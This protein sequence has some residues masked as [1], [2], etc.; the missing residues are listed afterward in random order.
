V[1]RIDPIIYINNARFVIYDPAED[2]VVINALEMINVDEGFKG[3]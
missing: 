2:E 1:V 3:I